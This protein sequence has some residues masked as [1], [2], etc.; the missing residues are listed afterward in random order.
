MIRV[1]EATKART[2]TCKH[3]DDNAGGRLSLKTTYRLALLVKSPDIK[4]LN[5]FMIL[6]IHS[7]YKSLYVNKD[8][9]HLKI[10]ASPTFSTSNR[11][12]I[13]YGARFDSCKN[14]TIVEG[15]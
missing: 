7:V 2:G 15:R 13:C 10:V 4:L 1:S 5:G 11:S 14:A 9:C 12:Q 8:Q 3:T 6:R